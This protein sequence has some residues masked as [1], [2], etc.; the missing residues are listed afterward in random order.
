[1]GA[2]AVANDVELQVLGS[3][4]V[5]EQD[6]AVVHDDVQGDLTTA[7]L[8]HSGHNCLGGPSELKLGAVDPAAACLGRLPSLHVAGVSIAAAVELGTVRLGIG[9]GVKGIEHISGR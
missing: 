1:M 8:G 6:A 5:P 7:R 3:G 4:I 9:A 2:I